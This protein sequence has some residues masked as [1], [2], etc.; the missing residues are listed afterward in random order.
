VGKRERWQWGKE[1]EM[2]ERERWQWGKERD[3]R[4]R[5][6][7]EQTSHMNLLIGERSSLLSC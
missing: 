7:T 4:E 2:I 3:D 5:E 1:R 6:M